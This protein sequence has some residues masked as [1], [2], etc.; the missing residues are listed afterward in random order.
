MQ[1]RINRFEEFFVKLWKNIFLLFTILAFLA[2]VIAGVYYFI[3]ANATAEYQQET[4]SASLPDYLK[5][6]EKKHEKKYKKEEKPSKSNDNNDDQTKDNFPKIVNKI[7]AN[8]N[9]YAAVLGQNPVADEGKFLAYLSKQ[10]RTVT[11]SENTTQKVLENLEQET[12]KLMDHTERLSKLPVTDDRR[13]YTRDF[14]KWFF[15]DQRKQL[16]EVRE[17]NTLAKGVAQDQRNSVLGIIP[18]L[19]YVGGA[20][21]FFLL[22]LVLIRVDLGI[23]KIT[24]LTLRIRNEPPLTPNVDEK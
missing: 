18:M 21:I 15:D 1:T 4:A 2:G 19:P 13:V 10:L 22:F 7:I 16:E 12:K 6:L 9:A 23:R 3:N 8:L 11:S 14:V 24:E 5:L 20:F 17:K